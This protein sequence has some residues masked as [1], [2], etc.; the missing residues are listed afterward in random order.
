MRRYRILTWHVHGN[1]LYYLTHAPHDFHVLSKP[2]RPAAYG[3]RC[4]A[5]PW[6]DNVHDCPVETVRGQR[7]DC[8]L[9]QS[10]EHWLHDQHAILSESQR[11][12]PRIYLEHDPPQQHPTNTPHPVTDRD[13]L[14]VHCTHFNALM[15]DN[16]GVPVRVIEHGVVVPEGLRW[17]GA[18]A[19][20]IVVINHLARRGRRLGA[21]VYARWREHLPLDLYGMAA[22]EAG[23]IGELPYA[24][25]MAAIARYRFFCHPVRYTSLGLA[26]CEAMSLG[27]PIVGLATTELARIVRDGETGYIDTDVERLA[28][29]MRALLEDPAEAARVGAA[30]QRVARERFAIGR[31]AADWDRAF[32]DM[33]G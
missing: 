8:V 30:G 26:L 33:I 16:G 4:G 24:E 27:C 5:L 9:F 7:F 2:G 20:G 10:R 6:G 1:Y 13:V 12:L 23:G 15:W 32:A 14:I 25:L 19:R 21:D 22:A 29:V 28:R 11:R 31:F 3:G 17:N 18:L